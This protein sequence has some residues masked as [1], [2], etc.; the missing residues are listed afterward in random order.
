MC[1]SDAFSRID[2]SSSSPSVLRSSVRSPSP[3]CTAL[4]G[5]PD[6]TRLP[7]TSMWPSSTASAPKIAR[8]SSER[9]EPSSPAMPRISPALTSKSIAFSV[10]AGLRPTTFSRASPSLRSG[11]CG[12]SDSILRPTIEAI[13]PSWSS[14][15]IIAVRAN[16]PSRRTVTRSPISNI[17]SRWC[18]TYMIAWPSSRSPWMRASSA[19]VSDSDSAVVGSSKIRTRGLAPSTFAISTSWR[20]ASEVSATSVFGSSHSRPTRS[21]I[22]LALRLSSPG[23]VT[24][25]RAGRR[26]IIRFSP[27]DRS[28]SRLSS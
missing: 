14:S 7:S 21:S 13:S 24:P 16:L 25:R 4:R 11:L 28:G 3:A 1:A 18:E 19:F 2:S 23:R 27:T 6:A 17:S 15:V 26:P 12:Y 5:L 20:T 22:A 9:P 10:P 8:S